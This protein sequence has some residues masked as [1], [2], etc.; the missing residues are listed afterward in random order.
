MSEPSEPKWHAAVRAALSRADTSEALVEANRRLLRLFGLYV[1]M[2]VAKEGQAL[3]AAEVSTLMEGHMKAHLFDMLQLADN[4]DGGPS[5]VASGALRESAKLWERVAATRE[6]QQDAEHL[7]AGSMQN[8]ANARIAGMLARATL[9]IGKMEGM[10]TIM[11]DLAPA[12]AAGDGSGR[13]DTMAER[14]GVNFP[15]LMRLH[16][17]GPRKRVQAALKRLTN[18]DMLE[19]EE[20]HI[21]RSDT[22]RGERHDIAAEVSRGNSEATPETLAAL[23][24]HDARRETSADKTF[25]AWAQGVFRGALKADPTAMTVRAVFDWV[26]A[27]AEASRGSDGVVNLKGLRELLYMLG[28]TSPVLLSMLA[29][30]RH[31]TVQARKEDVHRAEAYVRTR[32]DELAAVGQGR[33]TD[34]VVFNGR[35]LVPIAI[36]NDLSVRAEEVACL[37][38]SEVGLRNVAVREAA[39]QRSA[40][41]FWQMPA[42]ERLRVMQVPS[43]QVD[44]SQHDYSLRESLRNEVEAGQAAAHRSL[45]G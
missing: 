30:A 19:M 25:R 44:S 45:Y 9:S 38:L 12:D 14:A 5:G 4:V 40:T 37:V 31:N 10:T 39:Q 35:V 6:D 43:A 34:T 33:Q 21:R 36:A 15:D 28:H 17:E 29:P 18:A 41:E 16:L 13:T 2:V 27:W 1:N 11:L 26:V 20:E 23:R 32:S 42:H 7:F 8:L 24:V 22:S 3:T